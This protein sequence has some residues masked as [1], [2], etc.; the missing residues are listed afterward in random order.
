MM[1]DPCGTASVDN[2][3]SAS[4]CLLADIA[5]PAGCSRVHIL[6]ECGDLRA[7]SREPGE[8]GRPILLIQTRVLAQYR[9]CRLRAHPCQE[10]SD[11]CSAASGE[12]ERAH[13]DTPAQRTGGALLV[14]P[15]LW[16]SL[17]LPC[18]ISS[19]SH[20]SASSPR[21]FRAWPP[22]ST[23]GALK[24]EPFSLGRGSVFLN[25]F[26]VC[27]LFSVGLRRDIEV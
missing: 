2:S 9:F 17:P 22:P 16:V 19:F 1:P 12:D 10:R 15:I 3:I 24:K 13:R 5:A 4:S 18:M 20:H 8:A 26:T 6:R 14:L 21:L 11:P 7:D 25:G 23:V 27:L